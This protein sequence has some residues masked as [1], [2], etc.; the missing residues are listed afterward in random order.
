MIVK[1]GVAIIAFLMVFQP[2]IAGMDFPVRTAP[3]SQWGDVTFPLTAVGQSV[4]ST[5][6]LSEQIQSPQ[7]NNAPDVIFAPALPVPNGGVRVVTPVFNGSD[8]QCVR[9]DKDA[10]GRPPCRRTCPGG[11]NAR[12]FYL[13]FLLFIVVLAM[14]NVPDSMAFGMLFSARS[15]AQFNAG[16]FFCGVRRVMP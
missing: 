8:S 1:P 13:L 4:S 5:A 2:V 15:G 16:F 6:P 12:Y 14:S 11:D 9:A 10:P 3:S 7:Q